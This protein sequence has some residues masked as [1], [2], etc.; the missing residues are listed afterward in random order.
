MQKT[1]VKFRPHF[2]I[3]KIFQTQKMS[4]VELILSR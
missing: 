2:P 4:E 1:G 3:K